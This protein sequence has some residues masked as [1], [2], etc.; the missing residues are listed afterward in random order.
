MMVVLKEAEQIP[1]QH[2]HGDLPHHGHVVDAGHRQQ[3]LLVHVLETGHVDHRRMR[4]D[5]VRIQL[6][7][8]HGHPRDDD[9]GPPHARLRGVAVVAL[10]Q[11]PPLEPVHAVD[12]HG[13][14]G[15]AVVGEHGRQGPSHDLAPVDDGDDLALQLPSHGEGGVVAAVARLQDFHHAQRRAGDEAFVLVARR[16]D[17]A[18]VPVQIAAVSVAQTLHVAAEGHRVAEVVVLTGPAERFHLAEDGVVDDD[19]VHARIVVGVEQRGLHVDGIVHHAQVVADAVVLARA[20]RP[21][22]IF[23]GRRVVV[24]Q[25]AHQERGHYSLFL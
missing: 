1:F 6:V 13:V 17:V 12:V 19:A 10:V 9:G 24:G 11:P 16:I 21:L 25:D 5:P 2:G 15:G 3:R 22:G 7:G 14:H 20:A 18:D 8:L 23:A 4:S